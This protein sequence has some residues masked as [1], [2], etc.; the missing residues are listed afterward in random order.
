MNIVAYL[1]LLWLFAGL[2][3]GLSDALQVGSSGIMPS[4]LLILVVFISL[5]ATPG[6]AVGAALGVGLVLDLLIE[7]PAG[8][9]TNVVV[10]GPHALGNVLGAYVVLNIR[11]LMM[12][13][14]MWSLPAL[15]LLAGAVHHT[16]A[17][18]LLT[19]RSLYD[20]LIV[21]DAGGRLLEGLGS[22]GTSAAVAI[23]LGP[24]LSRL[25]PLMGFR[26]EHAASGM[27]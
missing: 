6:A 15:C 13:R 9:G 16:A 23:V 27:R 19:L 3:L 10:L 25:R 12:K 26:S 2:D 14:S 21:D 1:V 7:Q 5:W 18:G 8:Q 17:L 20:V 22:A 4:L 11:A 24:I